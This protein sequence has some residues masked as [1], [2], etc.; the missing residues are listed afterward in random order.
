[1]TA[2]DSRAVLPACHA[3]EAAPALPGAPGGGGQGARD[4][5]MILCRARAVLDRAQQLVREMQELL[6]TARVLAQASADGR[7][8]RVHGLP[9]PLRPEVLQRSEYMRLRPGWRPC[10]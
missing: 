8:A 3:L 6:A 1:M 9:P 5:A 10:R 2:L 7:R 4:R